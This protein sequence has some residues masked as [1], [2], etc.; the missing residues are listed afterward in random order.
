MITVMKPTNVTITQLKLK[1][2]ADVPTQAFLNNPVLRKNRVVQFNIPNRRFFLGRS[3]AKSEHV[4]SGEFKYTEHG[5]SKSKQDL[6]LVPIDGCPFG[7]FETMFGGLE[8][9]IR[10]GAFL[11]FRELSAL[12][13][14]EVFD[15]PTLVPTIQ[16]RGKHPHKFQ[17]LFFQFIRVYDIGDRR[18]IKSM[19][20]REEVEPDD[21]FAV[22]LRPEH[23]SS[24]YAG[25]TDD[26]D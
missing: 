10:S 7:Y 15:T 14:Q 2:N 13:L 19:N 22:V 4:V 8:D 24:V 18:Y 25:M 1:L 26:S 23:T 20:E 21:R 16:H 5:A 9:V 12:C 11:S 17:E 6:V 3:S